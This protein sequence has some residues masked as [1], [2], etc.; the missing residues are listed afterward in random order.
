MFMFHIIISQILD[1]LGL[2]NGKPMLQLNSSLEGAFIFITIN[3]D[4]FSLEI[5]SK[6]KYHF[7]HIYSNNFSFLTIF[8]VKFKTCDS[9]TGILQNSNA[10]GN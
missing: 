8:H 4:N 3:Q 1:I 2:P 9:V 7:I 5:D 6:L 10:F